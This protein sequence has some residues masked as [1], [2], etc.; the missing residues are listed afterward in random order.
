MRTPL[1]AGNWKLNKT[2]SEAVSFIE[3]LK[4]LVANTAGVEVLVCPVALSISSAVAACDDSGVLVGA[5]N[6]YWKDSGAYTG[7][8]SP[9]LLKDA[10]VSHVLVGHSERRGRF[11]VPE[12]DL[13]GE[14]GRVFGDTDASVNKKVLSLLSHELVPI[15]CVGETLEERK[16]G[17]TDAIV[18]AQ[19]KAAVEGVDSS[20]LGGLVFAYEP[21]WAIGTGETCAAEE[22]NRVCGVIRAAVESLNS[23]AAALVRVQYGGSVKPDNAREL[24]S[25]EHIDGA[26][27]GGASLKAD[28][29]A[30]IVRAAAA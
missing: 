1:I 8:L 21:V 14:A 18:A 11:G 9:A 4:P 2:V 30:S 26:L 29:F 23:A 10:G 22:A 17:Q 19:T 13:E 27:V 12:P 24:L 5:Q 7:E 25:Q 3:E 28:S 16:G 20:Q 6:T 15:I